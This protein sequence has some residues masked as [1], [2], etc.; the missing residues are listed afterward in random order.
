[1]DEEEDTKWKT[2]EKLEGSLRWNENF[3]LV[4]ILY[5]ARGEVFGCLFSFYKVA[6]L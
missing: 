1:M 2:T 5:E 6:L 3:W 4:E